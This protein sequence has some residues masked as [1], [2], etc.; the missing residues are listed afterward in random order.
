MRDFD[1]SQLREIYL[2][3]L[4]GKLPDADT[5]AEMAH[6][7]IGCCGSDEELQSDLYEADEIIGELKA[8]IVELEAK[9]EA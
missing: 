5:V 7:L 3:A 6:A 1:D 2:N 9:L 8:K 4:G